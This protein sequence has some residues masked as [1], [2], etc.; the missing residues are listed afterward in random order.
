MSAL[1]NTHIYAQQLLR[2]LISHKTLKNSYHQ[3][4]LVKREP[5]D[6]NMLLDQNNN[7]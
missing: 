6:E 5:N 7:M 3:A 2:E 1:S 4:K